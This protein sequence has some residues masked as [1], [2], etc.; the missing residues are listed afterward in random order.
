[1]K[2]LVLISILFISQIV[3][4]EGQNI[5]SDSPE[6]NVGPQAITSIANLLSEYKQ[7]AE[8]SGSDKTTRCT[9]AGAISGVRLTAHYLGITDA[10]VHFSDSD[11]LGN[12]KQLDKCQNYPTH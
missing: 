6:N 3:F 8:N 5:K 9:A 2:K 10:Q 11:I 7:L 4:A 1:M 12:M